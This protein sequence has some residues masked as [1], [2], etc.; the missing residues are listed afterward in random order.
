MKTHHLIVGNPTLLLVGLKQIISGMGDTEVVQTTTLKTNAIL[1]LVQSC[2]LDFLWVASRS[3]ENES[4]RFCRQMADSC[5]NVKIMVFCENT[6]S[7][8]I[9]GFLQAKANAYLLPCCVTSNIEEAIR[10][11][12]RNNVYIDPHLRQYLVDYMLNLRE[13]HTSMTALTKR[14]KEVLKL[15]VEENTTHEIAN[16][17]Y[18]NSCTVETHRLHLIQK[19]GVK[20]TAG[21]V[22]EALV[23]KL[24]AHP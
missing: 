10:A 21:L 20:N 23:R 15:I 9:R 3:P 18:I 2:S 16:K 24:Y 22:R 19:M 8:V 17:L 7:K 4:M 11:V 5:P 12:S 13:K 6:D 1:K 14:E